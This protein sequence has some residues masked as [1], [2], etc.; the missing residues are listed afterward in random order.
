MMQ[1]P[2]CYTGQRPM[3]DDMDNLR[4]DPR[5]HLLL[6]SYAEQGNADPEAWQDRIMDLPQVSPEALAK[7]HG[8]LLACAWLEQNTGATP[9]LQP[10]A[11][12]R[13]YRI[14]LAGQ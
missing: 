13:C 1:D 9:L 11:V 12:P 3:L 14:T 10:G 4:A 2:H 6:S 7:L 8:R 5:L